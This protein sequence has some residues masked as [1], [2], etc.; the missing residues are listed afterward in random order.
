MNI[1][2]VTKTETYRLKQLEHE[3]NVRSEYDTELNTL[4]Q[5]EQ[6]I[7]QREEKDNNI[8]RNLPSDKGHRLRGKSSRVQSHHPTEGQSI[9]YQNEENLGNVRGGSTSGG[10][11]KTRYPAYWKYGSKSRSSKLSTEGEKYGRDREG[12]HFEVQPVGCYRENTK[13]ISVQL[14]TLRKEEKIAKN[15]LTTVRNQ[16]IKLKKRILKMKQHLDTIKKEKENSNSSEAEKTTNGNEEDARELLQHKERE[17]QL[18]QEILRVQSKMSKIEILQQKSE[19]NDQTADSGTTVLPFSAK[20]PANELLTPELCS[21]LCY[22]FNTNLTYAG[23][24]NSNECTCGMNEPTSELVDD[25][26]CPLGCPGDTTTRCGSA[27]QFVSVYQFHP[28]NMPV[29]MTPDD[30]AEEAEAAECRD[31]QTHAKK[32]LDQARSEVDVERKKWEEAV[33]RLARPKTCK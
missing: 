2:V 1:N 20:I 16:G 9:E 11:I 33:V 13:G 26:F 4:T 24:R 18:T 5:E 21:A 31:N 28:T 32:I 10:S 7:Q 8:E 29:G 14:E 6:V 22:T 15:A 27:K 19:Q 17:H 23:V 3:K 30:I 12:R 25:E